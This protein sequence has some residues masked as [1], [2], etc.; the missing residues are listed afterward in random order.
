MASKDIARR[1]REPIDCMRL[2]DVVGRL[3]TPLAHRNS[4]IRIHQS[5]PLAGITPAIALYKS[6]PA[7]NALPRVGV[8]AFSDNF[9]TKSGGEDERGGGGALDCT[10]S[11]LALPL[12][13]AGLVEETIEADCSVLWRLARGEVGREGGRWV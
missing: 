12:E 3:T 11:G 6:Y 5:P 7:A 13:T 1:M 2:A 4:Q 9:F 8:F 10:V